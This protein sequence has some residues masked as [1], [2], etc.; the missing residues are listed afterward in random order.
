[1]RCFILIYFGIESHVAQVGSEI[2]Y[3]SKMGLELLILLFPPPKPCNYGGVPSFLVDPGEAGRSGIQGH[4]L[5][6]GEFKATLGLMG[7]C[8]K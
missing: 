6:H 1:M 7:P 8:L 2:Y 4:P 5:L 3:V